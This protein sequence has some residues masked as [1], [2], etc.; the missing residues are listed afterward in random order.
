MGALIWFVIFLIGALLFFGVAAYAAING[1][2]DL[3]ELLT[4]VKKTDKRTGL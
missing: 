1:M 3:R 2:R 4:R